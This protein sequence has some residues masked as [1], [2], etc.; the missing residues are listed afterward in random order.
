MEYDDTTCVQYIMA[1]GVAT[2]LVNLRFGGI[3]LEP[4]NWH[5]V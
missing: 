2:K 1:S 3:V 5:I 4:V